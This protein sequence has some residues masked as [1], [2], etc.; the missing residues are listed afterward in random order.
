MEAY[1]KLKTDDR[2]RAISADNVNAEAFL[3]NTSVSAVSSE[4]SINSKSK[5]SDHRLVGG[6]QY[7]LKE[8]GK[9]SDELNN[10]NARGTIVADENI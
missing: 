2:E 1:K 5:E 9:F 8:T 7:Q 6:Q 10:R 3:R 4:Y